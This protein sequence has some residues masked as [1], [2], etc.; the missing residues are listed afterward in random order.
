MY[1]LWEDYVSKSKDGMS[2]DI[3][4]AFGLFDLVLVK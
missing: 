2:K 1:G 4:L 3:S